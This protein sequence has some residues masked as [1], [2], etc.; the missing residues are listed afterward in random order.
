[1]SFHAALEA[2]LPAGSLAPRRMDA[3]TI[4]G[5]DDFHLLQPT[6]RALIAINSDEVRAIS[7]F[8]VVSGHFQLPSLLQI[9]SPSAIAT[10]L[11]EPRARLMSLYMYWRI[12]GIFDQ[13]APYSVQDHALKPLEEFLT[14]RLLAPA[15][16]NQVTRM[17]VGSDPRVP[18]DDFIAEADVES[19]AE[20]AIARLETLGF[21]GILERGDEAWVGLGRHFDVELEQRT[22]N[23]TGEIGEP[24]GLG[25][26]DE[27]LTGG[28]LDLL[29]HRNAIDRMIY[30]RGLTLVGSTPTQSSVLQ[31]EAFTSQ[32]ERLRDLLALG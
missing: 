9:A 1:M 29:E 10:I 27:G 4:C 22:D 26:K 32:L 18:E 31:A 16:D 21:V 8:P 28:C 19:L 25:S 12:P 2:V 11:R 24:I 23:E 6:T 30:E 14:D 5:F 3:S 20:N 15:T 13:L 17:L 7:A